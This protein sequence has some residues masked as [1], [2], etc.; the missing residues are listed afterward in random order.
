ML[1][2]ALDAD[3]RG[4]ARRRRG[5]RPYDGRAVSKRKGKRKGGGDSFL[6]A[7]RRIRKPMPP[8]EQIL[9]DRRRRIADE[10]ARR[11]IDEGVSSRDDSKE[12]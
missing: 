7:Y 6:D 12:P 5:S 2:G 9:A 10:D 4:V 3:K 8:P 11:E 1:S